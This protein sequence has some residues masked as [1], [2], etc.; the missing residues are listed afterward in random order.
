MVIAD[1]VADDFVIPA[2]QAM[3]NFYAARDS[4]AAFAP[5]SDAI[6]ILRARRKSLAIR[7]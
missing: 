1:I 5:C 7:A 6:N 3:E 2:R 4:S